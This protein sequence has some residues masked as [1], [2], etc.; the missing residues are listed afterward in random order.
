MPYL[1]LFCVIST[2]SYNLQTVF[3]VPLCSHGLMD[4]HNFSINCDYYFLFN[5]QIGQCDTFHCF[6]AVAWW[7]SPLQ[8]FPIPRCKKLPF[9]SRLRNPTL[10]WRMRALVVWALWDRVTTEG[11]QTTVPWAMLVTG[12]KK[13]L[14][15]HWIC[16]I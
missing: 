4:T 12:P 9:R 6:L 5:A 8:Y 7:S 14:S 1:F 13:L 16:L 11:K 15:S 10:L 3:C 2:F